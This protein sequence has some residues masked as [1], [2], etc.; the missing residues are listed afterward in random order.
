MVKEF[1]KTRTA[2]NDGSRTVRVW[3]ESHTPRDHFCVT[4][5]LYG[6]ITV[7]SMDFRDGDQIT[8]EVEKKI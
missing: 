3:K 7:E 8:L 6:N 2:G 5:A 4:D 1:K